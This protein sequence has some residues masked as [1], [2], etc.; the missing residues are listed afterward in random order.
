MPI[1]IPDTLPARSVLDS[2][3]VFVMPQTRAANQ[4]I[5]P[6]KILIFNLMP[7]KITTETHLLRVLS[8]TP[9]QV[10]VDLLMTSSH[11]SKNTPLEHLTAFYHTFHEIKHQKYDGMIITG[12]PVE[13]MDFEEVNYWE[14]MKEIM[15]W[16][17]TNVTCTFHICWGAQAGLYYHFG[18]PKHH[19]GKKMFGVFPHTVN[20]PQE[21]LVRGFDDLFFAPHSRYTGV[22]REEMLNK[23]GLIIVSESNEAGVY[24]AMSANRRQIFVTGHSEYDPNT[25]K[26]EYVRDVRKGLDIAIP[27]NYFTNNDPSQ[28][29]MVTWRSHAHLLYSNW[30]N[31][32]VYQATPFV[33]DEI[34]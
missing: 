13:E 1:K 32:Y 25:L 34:S 19:L 21:P 29:P 26:E 22:K 33:L 12:A 27:A 23:E 28:P 4:D 31:Y 30:L 18:I 20:C 2:E 9:L 3:N 8:N 24:I 10:E 11:I 15:E 17:K 6:L 14:E 5:R 16:S 7:L